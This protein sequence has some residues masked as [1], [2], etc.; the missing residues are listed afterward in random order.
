[1][2]FGEGALDVR[3]QTAAKKITKKAAF[4]TD[5]INTTYN[6]DDLRS[7]VSKINVNKVDFMPRW[8]RG[9]V[10]EHRSVTGEPSLSYARP[11]AD[12]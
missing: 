1:L 8:L 2:Q 6:A 4:C 5:N 7:F 10:V 3:G 12:G 9:T 11:A